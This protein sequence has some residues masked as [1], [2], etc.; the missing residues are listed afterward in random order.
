MARRDTRLHP[1]MEPM[2]NDVDFVIFFSDVFERA[3][4]LSDPFK[5]KRVP[6]LERSWVHLVT[7]RSI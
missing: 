5:G 6:H 1:G 4:Q 3:V 7:T 2:T